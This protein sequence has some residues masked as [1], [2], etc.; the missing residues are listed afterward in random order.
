MKPFTAL[1]EVLQ[2]SALTTPPPREVAPAKGDFQPLFAPG[3]S[4]ADPQ[5]SAAG[6]SHGEP[7]VEVV[8]A[9]GR[10][11]QI[12]VVCPCG[13]RTVIECAY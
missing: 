9:D 12:I 10:V 7:Q 6:A 2:S 3:G 8:E 11:Q 4:G 1:D 5:K 13:E